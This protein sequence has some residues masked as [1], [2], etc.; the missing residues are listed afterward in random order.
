MSVVSCCASGGDRLESEDMKEGQRI[1]L[2]S[3]SCAYYAGRGGTAGA[4]PRDGTDHHVTEA[5]VGNPLLMP[6][7]SLGGPERPRRTVSRHAHS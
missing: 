1:P 6:R 7:W 3:L 5:L 2:G 4:W